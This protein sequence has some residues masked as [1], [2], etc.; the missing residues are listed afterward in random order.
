MEQEDRISRKRR[1][2]RSWRTRNPWTGES[3]TF[4]V[5]ISRDALRVWERDRVDLAAAGCPDRPPEFVSP[6]QFVWNPAAAGM[7]LA[8]ADLENVASVFRGNPGVVG[9]GIWYSITPD[10]SV[11]FHVGRHPDGTFV[12]HF[13]LRDGP[14]VKEHEV[15]ASDAAAANEEI[16][17]AD[18]AVIAIGLPPLS[19]VSYDELDAEIG[20]AA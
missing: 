2:M 11:E 15:T 4:P 18:A 9:L 3:E 6:H 1:V 12:F 10:V 13:V 14:T 5:C 19:W 16:A 8:S 7:P 17:T 20:D